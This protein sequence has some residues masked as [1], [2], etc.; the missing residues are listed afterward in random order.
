MP[1]IPQELCEQYGLNAFCESNNN[2]QRH[3]GHHMYP[4]CSCEH[5]EAAADSTLVSWTIVLREVMDEKVI[6]KTV[7]GHRERSVS[8]DN[9]HNNF[10]DGKNSF[11]KLVDL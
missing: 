8:A 1:P 5:T 7:V 4:K 6:R 9:N 3:R 11:T 10:R 2:A